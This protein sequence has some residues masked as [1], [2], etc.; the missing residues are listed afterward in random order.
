MENIKSLDEVNL[1][2]ALLRDI[3][4]LHSDVFSTYSMHKTTQKVVERVEREGRGFLTK[5][6][7]RLGKSLDQA[8]SGRVSFDA[9]GFQKLPNSSLPVLLGEL[10]E[11][12]FA[13]DGW[14]LPKPSIQCIKSLRQFLY[15]FYKYE[16]PYSPDEELQVLK[17]FVEVDN[18]LDR[19]NHFGDGCPRLAIPGKH[20]CHDCDQGN[21]CPWGKLEVPV[22]GYKEKPKDTVAVIKRARQLLAEVFRV[23]DRE[24][25]YPRHGPGSVSTKEERSEKYLF[26]V[27]SPRIAS[28]YPVDA[29]FFASLGHVCD[30]HEWLQAIRLE[31]RSA[32]VVLV[33]KDSRGPRLISEEPL[34]FQWI[35]QGLHRAMVDHVENHPL[36]RENVFFTDQ[37]PNQLGALL[38]SQ[39]EFTHVRID[40]TRYR[41][42][43]VN[44]RY[45]TLDLKEASDRVSLGLVRLL[46]PEP[47]LEALM[48]CRSLE[49]TLPDGQKILLNKY[50][51]MGS[52]LCFPV[53][54]L[55]IWAL[56]SAAACDADARKSIHVFGDDVIVRS[57]QSVIA[58]QVLESFGLMVNKTKSYAS[59]FFRESC[60]VDAYLGE[61]VTPV[62]LHTVWTSTRRADVYESWISYANSFYR[63]RYFNLY[64]MIVTALTAVY[65]RIPT[66]EQVGLTCPAL[67]DV[68]LEHQPNKTRVNFALQKVERRVWCVRSKTSNE[69]LGGWWMLLRYFAERCP[70][71]I[72]DLEVK[73]LK[74]EA[75]HCRP[76]EYERRHFS[77]ST[78][79]H[80]RSSMLYRGW[81]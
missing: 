44:G 61:N 6:L 14:V 51:P 74:T 22:T 66:V 9:V 49:T 58:I 41:Y 65:G 5:A 17:S 47:L 12:V 80:R 26:K 10:F 43:L 24:A 81:R 78:Y 32:K 19:F 38:G 13:H 33:P 69:D 54:A 48:A 72:E 40:G 55:T 7:P 8:L 75:E 59:G 31:E 56:L 45:A 28:V 11:C 79:T 20:S 62:R 70:P 39:R 36:T 34:E 1:I 2:A 16:L 57:D 53:M 46:W 4:L 42:W 76:L 50:A 67:V 25:I 18:G 21:A 35:Q 37:G 29:Y 63:R 64:D 15:L 30:R 68:P 23:F 52:A 77:V 27:V 71:P 73:L 3:Q 60:G